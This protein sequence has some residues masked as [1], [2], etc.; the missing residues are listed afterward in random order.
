[1]KEHRFKSA[2]IDE[3]WDQIEPGLS[4]VKARTCAAWDPAHV[5]KAVRAGEAQLMT[6][7]EG[8]IVWRIKACKFTGRIVFWLWIA[9]GEGGGIIE[10]Y[11]D[12]IVELARCCG[13]DAV[14]FESNRRGYLRRMRKD[15]SVSQVVYE[16][17]V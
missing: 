17:D 16:R 3:V 1:M 10:R 5:R 9:Y 12:Q 8:F 4:I 13:A 14:A 2:D 6:G 7:P 11:E 15:W